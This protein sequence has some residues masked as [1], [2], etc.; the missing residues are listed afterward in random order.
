MNLHFDCIEY[1]MF[2][3]TR[4]TGPA[5]EAAGDAEKESPGCGS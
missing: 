1:M 4:R 3:R 5:A 2:V